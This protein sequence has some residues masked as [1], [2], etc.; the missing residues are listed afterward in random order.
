MCVLYSFSGGQQNADSGG[1]CAVHYKKLIA[2]FNNHDSP[3]HIHYCWALMKL[4]CRFTIPHAI[5]GLMITLC[6][7]RAPS[8]RELWEMEF[9]EIRKVQNRN[10]NTNSLRR[11]EMSQVEKRRKTMRWK[12]RDKRDDKR[13]EE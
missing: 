6:D 4:I 10:E 1:T 9:R 11:E 8:Q 5:H 3:S 12:R 13:G 7:I 2:L